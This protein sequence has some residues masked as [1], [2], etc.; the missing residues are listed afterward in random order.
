[1]KDQNIASSVNSRQAHALRLKGTSSINLGTIEGTLNQNS[2]LTLEAWVRPRTLHKGVE[3][4]SEFKFKGNGVSFKSG[5]YDDLTNFR[6]VNIDKDS[7]AAEPYMGSLSVPPGWTVVLFNEFGCRGR[8]IQISSDVFNIS[9]IW[10]GFCTKSMLV[11]NKF[12]RQQ[13]Y[14]VI[15]EEDHYQGLGITISLRSYEDI[16]I[17]RLKSDTIN[18]LIVP[19][20]LEVKLYANIACSGARLSVQGEISQLSDLCQGNEFSSIAVTHFVEIVKPEYKTVSK[21][22][23]EIENG[24][25]NPDETEIIQKAN[26]HITFFSE[27]GFLGDKRIVDINKSKAD[28]AFGGGSVHIHEGL[29]LTFYIEDFYTESGKCETFLGSQSMLRKTFANDGYEI[30]SGFII[31]KVAGKGGLGIW[32]ETSATTWELPLGKYDDLSSFGK[33]ESYRMRPGFEI[34]IFD[35]KGCKGDPISKGT[36]FDWWESK[37]IPKSAKSLMVIK[38]VTILTDEEGKGLFLKQIPGRLGI[39][40]P[41]IQF[42]GARLKT[43]SWSHIALTFQNGEVAGYLNGRKIIGT[44]SFPEIPTTMKPWILGGGFFGD[45]RQVAIWSKVDDAK[46]RAIGRFDLIKAS[47]LDLVALWMMEAGKGSFMN[48]VEKSAT[49]FL[50]EVAGWIETDLP[51]SPIKSAIGQKAFIAANKNKNDQVLEAR[52]A[53]Q[54]V[55]AAAQRK[56]DTLLNAAHAR[57]SAHS[58][59]L[60]HYINGGQR[61]FKSSRSFPY[62]IGSHPG[63]VS[64]KAF[65]TSGGLLLSGSEDGTLCLWEI[66]SGRLKATIKITGNLSGITFYAGKW[67]VANH[68]GQQWVLKMTDLVI[69]KT[70]KGVGNNVASSGDDSTIVSLN[71]YSFQLQI[72]NIDGTILETVTRVAVDPQVGIAISHEGSW[73]VA[74]QKK[75]PSY[76]LQWNLASPKRPRMATNREFSREKLVSLAM[77]KSGENFISGNYILVCYFSWGNASRLLGRARDKLFGDV[78]FHPNG[79]HM[80]ACITG[81]SFIGVWDLAI[82]KSNEEVNSGISHLPCAFILHLNKRVTKFQISPDGLHIAAFSGG[83]ITLLKWPSEKQESVSPKLPNSSDLNPNYL[84]DLSLD[85]ISN[86]IYAAKGYPTGGIM[87]GDEI[88]YERPDGPVFS[89]ALDAVEEKNLNQIYWIEN[90]G[91]LMRAQ[92]DGETQTPEI[93][94]NLVPGKENEWD[95]EVDANNNKIYWCNGREIWCAD[96]KNDKSFVNPR[97]IV[98]NSVSPHPVAIAINYE[99]ETLYWLDRELNSL[100]TANG[101]GSGVRDLYKTLHP[102][103]GLALDVGTR[104]LYWCAELSEM[105]E[106]A[107]IDDP[108]LFCWIQKKEGGTH[109]GQQV[110]VMQDTQLIGAKWIEFEGDHSLKVLAL[111]ESRDHL[112]IGPVYLDCTHGFSLEIWLSSE[113]SGTGNIF[114]LGNDLEGDSISL[115]LESQHNLVFKVRRNKGEVMSVSAVIP[116][117]QNTTNSNQA[118]LINVIATI[119]NVGIGSIIVNGTE[120]QNGPMVCPRTCFMTQNYI[121]AGSSSESA[122]FKGDIA[123]IRA[124]NQHLS[125]EEW[126]ILN[127]NMDSVLTTAKEDTPLGLLPDYSR[128]LIEQRD[129]RPHLISGI[130]DATVPSEALYPL[131]IDRGLCLQS[132]SAASHEKLLKAHHHKEFV[133]RKSAA[134]LAKKRKEAQAQVAAAHLSHRLDHEKADKLVTDA[135]EDARMQRETHHQKL[136]NAKVSSKKRVEQAHTDGKN[137]KKAADNT[138]KDTKNEAYRKAEVI[139]RKANSDL[140][141]AQSKLANKKDELN[142]KS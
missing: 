11:I 74:A 57:A 18:S 101:D 120:V 129:H 37:K 111:H 8:A 58:F 9:E 122:F 131:N 80:L 112:S 13:K 118:I 38:K 76:V 132:K 95:L 102:K 82:L 48:L 79:K 108:G 110:R 83:E 52:R 66:P 5:K 73:M 30:D 99:K 121:G 44:D 2:D 22:E 1:M 90:K 117:L 25:F 138:A 134:D 64:C 20:G 128:S 72:Q 115:S 34:L 142:K 46:K 3:G 119:D 86:I 141:S 23:N 98:P 71:P 10:N 103:A 28:S 100:R 55:L 56:A 29:Q 24:N 51:V 133:L 109:A 15:F 53:G 35:Q 45:V 50:P 97:V 16:A 75:N 137:Q 69:L 87:K 43:S 106:A 62:I 4:H 92:M 130:M 40:P 41:E 19:P 14:A 77:D 85:N 139:K 12:E 26:N 59:E 42:C 116:D 67:L 61:A 140:S 70:T 91:Q 21:E 126:G 32:L 84:T 33:I 114:K 68:E 113:I 78:A 124:W 27:P 81:T 6:C 31:A 89:I 63:E 93:L 105:I 54:K 39:S 94:A 123:T 65:S 17:L 104:R 60:V 125:K 96:L 127:K 49:E 7:A 47:D 36:F 136:K 88:L 135:N 107:V